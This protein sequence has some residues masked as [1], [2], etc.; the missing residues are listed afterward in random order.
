MTDTIYMEQILDHWKSPRNFGSLRNPDISHK[1]S[2]PLCGDE[3][4]IQMKIR[5]GRISD[6]RFTGKGCTISQA[7]TS[8]LTEFVKGKTKEDVEKITKEDL[9]QLLGI[10]I[11]PVRLKCA[12]LS[13]DTI[14]NG[15]KIHEAYGK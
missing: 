13:L 12:L 4:E 15:I 8:L 11:S 7:S 14:K 9:L 1:E 3:L 10:D 6:I 5:G 2:N